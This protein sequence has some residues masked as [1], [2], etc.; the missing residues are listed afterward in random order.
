MS[1]PSPLGFQLDSTLPSRSRSKASA[2]GRSAFKGTARAG[3]VAK[4]GGK[5]PLECP[6]SVRA[7]PRPERPLAAAYR[8]TGEQYFDRTIRPSA[9]CPCWFVKCRRV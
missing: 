8:H 1:L 2:G 6:A 3:G 7:C 4:E 5:H 9:D